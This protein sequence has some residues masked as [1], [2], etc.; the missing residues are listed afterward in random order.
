MRH[1][2]IF[3]QSSCDATL[4]DNIGADGGAG[5][6]EKVGAYDHLLVF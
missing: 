1:A 2:C 5:R 4:Y 3:D 6:H